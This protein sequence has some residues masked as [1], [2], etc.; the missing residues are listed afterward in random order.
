M[1]AGNPTGMIRTGGLLCLFRGERELSFL[2]TNAR[3]RSYRL[4]Q[5]CPFPESV[6]RSRIWAGCLPTLPED[7]T[8]ARLLLWYSIAP[9]A[10]T[11]VRG[12]RRQN[13]EGRWFARCD[14]TQFHWRNP[15]DR[16]D[17]F[18][19]TNGFGSQVPAESARRQTANDG[20]VSPRGRAH[21]AR[22]RTVTAHEL[23]GDRRTIVSATIVRCS[24]FVH[25]AFTTH[26]TDWR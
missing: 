5:N 26:R 24:A 4:A 3:M 9:Q 12:Q 16:L 21:A 8:L 6:D 2:K 7:P 14:P 17:P 1:P 13:P 23:I 22:S 10:E 19:V 25:T 18:N 15:C 20:P 11:K